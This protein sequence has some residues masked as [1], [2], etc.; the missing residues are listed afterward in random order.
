MIAPPI[1]V[2]R[3]A[4]KKELD[5]LLSDCLDGVGRAALLDGAVGSGKTELLNGVAERASDFGALVLRAACSYAEQALP[6]GV[7]D[8]LLR[9]TRLPDGPVEEAGRWLERAAAEAAIVGPSPAVIGAGMAQVFR[10][11]FLVLVEIARTAPVIIGVD[12][13]HCAD[14]SSLHCLLYLIRRLGSARMMVVVTDNPELSSAHPTFRSELL[15]QQHCRRLELAPLSSAGVRQLLVHRF[16]QQTADR[17]APE[18]LQL[19]GGNPSLLHALIADRRATGNAR[20]ERYGRAVL[21]LLHRS[22]TPSVLRTARALA[23]LGDDASAEQLAALAKVEPP[24]VDQ[25]LRLMT[26]AGLLADGRF[27]HDAAP[28]GILED[29][30]TQDRVE[31]H[32]RAATMLHEQAATAT[33][34]ARHLLAA[35]AAPEPWAVPV[36]LESAGKDQL[37]GRP[38]AA[39]AALELASRGEGG[40]RQQAAIATMLAHCRW[41]SGPQLAC[42]DFESLISAATAGK[43]DHRNSLRLVRQLLWHGWSAA[44]ADVLATV[45]TSTTDLHSDDSM[46]DLRGTDLWIAWTYPPLSHGRPGHAEPRRPAE[47][48]T[49]TAAEDWSDPAVVLAGGL[50]R[51]RSHEVVAQAEQVLENRGSAHDGS[52]AEE[53]T[54]LAVSVLMAAGRVGSAAAWCD[55]LLA[56]SRPQYSPTWKA[57]LSAARA[58]AAV[59]QGDLAPAVEH[60]RL[61]LSHLTPSSWGVIIGFPVSSLIL[62]TTRMGR[63]DEAA[64]YLARPVSEA[65]FQ[66]R[67]GL[68]YLHARGQYSL[69]TGH[70]HAALSDFQLCGELMRRWGIDVPGIVPWRTSAA[71]AW[72]RLGHGDQASRLIN[73]Q[74]GHAGSAGSVD[75][76][77]AL[78][79][80][81]VSMPAKSRMEPLAEALDLLEEC[82]DQYEQIRT[83]TDLSVACHEVG[84]SSRARVHA[85]RARR[86]AAMCG[87]APLSQ[88][89]LGAPG[90]REPGAPAD[91]GP[92]CAASL[93]ES[94]CRV[95]TL[96]VRGY[97]NREIATKLFVS[98]STVE[99]HLTRVYR[100][101]GVK[102]RR[103][104]PVGLRQHMDEHGGHRDPVRVSLA[105]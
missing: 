47:P 6:F 70:P 103:S 87:G 48:R 73:D 18:L 5:A 8:Q 55:R 67:Y 14:G 66:N 92:D 98:A 75:Q 94:E 91:D 69:A 50:L 10:G 104:L 100:K 34:V 37:D 86:L 19:S 61:A 9:S 32:R 39:I 29:L 13:V 22:S 42:R 88:A 52:W 40:E 62:A 105:G 2:E 102:N 46:T 35:D 57:L 89:L 4:Q 85:R 17:L 59:R 101:L 45:R 63:F 11:L 72:L 82:G 23:A 77:M 95:A 21:A 99:Q 49:A 33:E 71:E 16:D 58:D 93:T 90:T 25:A 26:A 76:A 7:L 36:L 24:Q 64:A 97:T 31:L 84:D 27:R 56:R 30:A 74:L 79:L 3:G 51:G 68:H 12:D 28:L 38:Q 41:Q 15:D 60:S 20:T 80:L 1:I 96:A 44:A 81:A 65:I 83:L 78:R 43:L 54:L 53:S